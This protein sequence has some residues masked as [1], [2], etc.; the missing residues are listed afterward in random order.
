MAFDVVVKMRFV[1]KGTEGEVHNDGER[2]FA[3]LKELAS[4]WIRLEPLKVVRLAKLDQLQCTVDSY[5]N[6]K[7]GSER[8]L[9]KRKFK[10]THLPTLCRKYSIE[11]EVW[12]S[13]EVGYDEHFVVG[14]DGKILL[15]DSFDTTP[16]ASRYEDW[17]PEP[18]EAEWHA[19]WGKWTIP[20]R[21]EFEA[22][23]KALQAK[24]ALQASIEEMKD[25]DGMPF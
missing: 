4:G 10:A 20:L 9:N 11:A 3:L 23:R 18:A 15:K 8:F 13:G 7:T 1:A 6:T 2:L 24:K 14:Y 12:T 21:S 22:R 19:R 17:S 5:L 25:P 16:Y